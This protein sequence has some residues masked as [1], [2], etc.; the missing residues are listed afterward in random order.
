MNHKN[1]WKQLSDNKLSN[2]LSFSA[3]SARRIKIP[4]TLY[5]FFSINEDKNIDLI[6]MYGDQ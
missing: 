1:S 3:I 4:E 2:L 5:K 6:F